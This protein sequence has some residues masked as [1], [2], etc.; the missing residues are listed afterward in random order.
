[1]KE[2][3]QSMDDTRAS[4]ALLD[5]MALFKSKNAN[6]NTIAKAIG[7]DPAISDQ[8]LRE[9]NSP[10]YSLPNRVK[11]LPHAI[12]LIGFKRTQEIVMTTTKHDMYEQVENSYFE[13]LAFK[14][15]GLAVGCFA[16]QLAMHL[17]LQ[18]PKEFFK[19]GSLHDIGKYFYLNRAPAQF[20]TL[21]KQSRE[22]K[23]PLYQIERTHL[24]TDHAEIGSM[25]A[26]QW[27]LPEPICVAIRYHHECPDKVKDRLTSRETQ[28][29]QV[30]SYA[31]LLA[32]GHKD[33]G[34]S[35]GRRVSIKDL[36]PP[37]GI[38]N[39]EDL[40][41]IIVRAEAQFKDECEA[42]G[43]TSAG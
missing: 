17:K 32:H 26:H 19:A 5:T 12:S 8:I 10:H 42:S 35:T 9:V 29:V 1:M 13:L 6:V 39:D 7:F 30:V 38:L 23:I 33:A 36:P 27:K 31:N 14:K 41:K 22:E 3:A 20:E 16:E 18:E 11:E 25:M 2:V 15:H 40:A 28:M 24:K 21:V 4:I 34:V 43:L 37:P